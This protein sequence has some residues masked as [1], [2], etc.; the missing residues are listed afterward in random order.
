MSTWSTIVHKAFYDNQGVE[1][2]NPNCIENDGSP[3]GSVTAKLG[4][5]CWDYTNSD[6]YINTDGS[7]TW[8]Q[9]NA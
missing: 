5:L 1:R 2:G 4:T 6:A 3:N 7:T 9:I 8:V